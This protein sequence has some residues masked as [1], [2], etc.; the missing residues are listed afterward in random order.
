MAGTRCHMLA[1]YVVLESYVGM[2]CDYRM[3]TKDGRDLN[4]ER[5]YRQH[6]MK[7]KYSTGVNKFITIARR[8]GNDWFV[9]TI[10]DNTAREIEISLNFLAGGEYTADIYTDSAKKQQDL[11]LLEKKTE[12]VKKTD[13]IHLKNYGR[14]R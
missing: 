2:L 1:M 14:W 4:F 12:A 8:K 7:Q 6:G 10:N 9:G 5:L 3:R 13:I 11:N